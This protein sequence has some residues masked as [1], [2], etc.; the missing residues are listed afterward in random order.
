MQ[1]RK[2][3]LKSTNFIILIVLLFVLVPNDV[4]AQNSSTN[5]VVFENV[6]VFDGK[7]EQLILNQNV[8]IE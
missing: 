3:I 5:K 6:N 1:K 2:Q 8:L 7:N 4:I